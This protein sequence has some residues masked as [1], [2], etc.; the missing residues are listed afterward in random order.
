M[1]VIALRCGSM[2]RR[3]DCE[4]GWDALD[5]PHDG[6]S[7]R[8]Q[9]RLCTRVSG[10]VDSVQ[11]RYVPPETWFPTFTVDSGGDPSRAGSRE[12]GHL[13]LL[14]Q[15]LVNQQVRGRILMD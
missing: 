9:E 2:S 12:E 14:L 6:W 7:C 1:Y 13:N 5:Q 10:A 11:T 4:P 8:C 15:K 3:R